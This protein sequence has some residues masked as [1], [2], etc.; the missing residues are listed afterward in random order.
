MLN[1]FHC[2]FYVS[3]SSSAGALRMQTTLIAQIVRFARPNIQI[4]D[5]HVVGPVPMGL[6][7]VSRWRE[8]CRYERKARLNSALDRISER[9]TL[10]SNPKI[11]SGRQL[12]KN[13]II[14]KF[15]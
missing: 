1:I 14:I 11:R 2:R 4:H 13:D 6:C 5:A 7:A 3:P 12:S 15:Q 8:E 9:I 10:A